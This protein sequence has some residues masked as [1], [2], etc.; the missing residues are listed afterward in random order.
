[1]DA[2]TDPAV[3]RVTFMKSARVGYTQILLHLIAYHMDCEPCPI[4]VVQPTIDEAEAFSKEQV[5]P[6]LRDLKC[7]Q[8][9]VSDPKSRDS[10]NTLRLKTFRGGFLTLVGANAPTGF[11]RRN[12][13][14]V[15]FDETDAY[16]PSAGSEGDQEK[17]GERR[18][19]QFWNRKIVKGSTPTVKDHSRIER[20]FNKSD[21]R[22]FF[23]PCPDCDHMQY[24]KWSG[25]TWEKDDD[26]EHHPET[27]RYACENCG[28]LI[29]HSKKA[30]M[31]ERGEWRSTNPGHKKGHVGFHIWAGY[32]LA[33]N[34]AWSKLVEEFLEAKDNPE[35][36]QTFVNTILGE[37]FERESGDG[38][39]PEGLYS[40]R[41]DYPEE[42][43]PTEVL[44]LTAAVDVQVDRLECEIKGW[45]VGE[46]SWG[47][48]YLVIQGDPGGDDVW[49]ELDELLEDRWKTKDGRELHIACM[50]IDS[51]G[52]QTQRVYDY[53]R[54]RQG[55]RVFALKGRSERGRPIIS[56]PSKRR[57]AQVTVIPVGTDTA[58]D[59]IFSRLNLEQPGPG[60]F[61]FPMR[62][63]EHYFDGLTA[64]HAVTRYRKGI[65]FREWVPKKRG[66]PNEP[67]DLA[68]YNL[69]A[70]R[71]LNPNWKRL[72]AKRA[73]AKKK[74]EEKKAVSPAKQ[75]PKPPAR[76]RK[77]WVNSWRS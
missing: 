44:C 72:E 30:W 23:V 17:L 56:R 62:Y 39:E 38:V 1:M 76:K 34:A 47:V 57:K 69:A 6:M 67:I 26:G 19:Q 50:G 36:L 49:D 59:L 25:L 21:Q 54:P 66:G 73:V 58:K 31:L 51:G 11:R 75:R 45:G 43:L 5:A 7:L 16:P 68:V 46:E 28:S 77:N 60:Y 52:L 14:I 27:V 70:V 55:R 20:N 37:T 4:M 64:E 65:P 8:G 9:K 53:V 40:R 63:D 10:G 12:I 3:E 41:E 2:L 22:R 71:F 74:V 61:H 24:L 42:P 15:L 29:P 32:S 18:T 13:R 33:S 35:T 48:E